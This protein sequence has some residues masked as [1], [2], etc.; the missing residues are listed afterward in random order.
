MVFCFQL[1]KILQ[2]RVFQKGLHKISKILVPELG[3]T[4]TFNQSRI[5]LRKKEKVMSRKE[6]KSNQT[7]FVIIMLSQCTNP[8][9]KCASNCI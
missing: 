3:E 7:L 4:K 5:N 6:E 8:P 2:K 9:R 1:K